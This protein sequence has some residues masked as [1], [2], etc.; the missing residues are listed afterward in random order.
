MAFTFGPRRGIYID[1]VDEMKK[2]EPVLS[3]E[4]TQQFERFDLIYRSLCT[5]LFN[6]VPTSGHPGGS[7]SSGRFVMGLLYD[8]MDYDF[9]QPDRQD[10]D[11]LSYAAGHKALGLYALWALRN[12]VVRI[13][14]PDFLPGEERSQLRLEDLFG[15]RRNPIARTSLIKKF[16]VKALDGHPT[17]A[18]PF[19]RLSTGASGVGM[20]SSIG[21][22]IGA[23]DYFGKDA[24]YVHIVEGEGGMTPGRAYEAMACAGTSSLRNVILHVDWNQASIDSNRVCRDGEVPGDYVQWNPMEVAYLHDWNVIRV[25]EGRDFQQIFAAQRKARSIDNNQPTAIV[26]RT[27]KGWHYGIEGKASHGAGHKLCADGFYEALK[28]LLTGADQRLPQCDA[29]NQRCE[30][31]KASEIMEGC[32]WEALTIIRTEMEKSRAM[33]EMLAERLV[34]ARERLEQKGRRPRQDRPRLERLFETASKEGKNIPE[35]LKLVP[36]SLAAPSGHTSPK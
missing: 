2:G 35:E 21:L 1:I 5:M 28:P 12:E 33:A 31:G 17:P 19:V 16:H 6:Y 20:G 9:S 26:Y 14:R 25:P 4:E 7:I 11:I 27:L 10:A 30:A 24:P 22:A 32:F 36:G 13:A 18:T 34:K 23:F 8:G 29:A 3:I 15:F